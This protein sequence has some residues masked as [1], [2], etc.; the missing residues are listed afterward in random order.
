MENTSSHDRS[1]HALVKFEVTAAYL[2]GAYEFV[3]YRG[4]RPAAVV[5]EIWDDLELRVEEGTAHLGPEYAEEKQTA[6]S[7]IATESA[8]FV[9]LAEAGKLGKIAEMSGE[10]SVYNPEHAFAVLASGFDEEFVPACVKAL[11]DDG[12]IES[13]CEVWAAEDDEEDEEDDEE[14]EGDEDDSDEDD[15]GNAEYRKLA[16]ELTALTESGGA[17]VSLERLLACL[18]EIEELVREDVM[19]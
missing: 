16:A 13:F 9:A 10:V 4:A 17:N 11:G 6:L 3:H 14:G 7:E 5:Q 8:Q 12:E 18:S 1:F 15:D 19:G 2:S